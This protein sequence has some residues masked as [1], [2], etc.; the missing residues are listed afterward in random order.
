MRRAGTVAT[1]SPLAALVADVFLLRGHLEIGAQAVGIEYAGQHEI[2]G[3]VGG[4]D[5]ARHAGQE[6]GQAGARAGRQIEAEQRHFHRARGDVDDAAEFF[7]DHRIDRLLDQLDRHDHVG[8]DAVDHLLPV[9]FAEVAERR[10]GIVVDQ[11]VRL[12]TGLEQRLLTLRRSDVGGDR[13]D[14]GAGRL[15]EFG[16]GGGEALAVAAVDHDL[17]A[18]LGERLGAGA[19][20]PAARCADDRLAAG[21]AEVHAGFPPF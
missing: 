12:G 5:R 8:D 16:G 9:E 18:G 2:D 20:E 4:G 14:L 13:D 17:A 19:A 11:N 3:D 7:G 10:A 1:R 6:G 21:D 15:A